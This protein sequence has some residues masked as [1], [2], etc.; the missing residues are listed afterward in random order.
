MLQYFNRLDGSD[1]IT[2][3]IAFSKNTLSGGAIEIT[4]FPFT[5]QNGGGTNLFYPQ[6]AVLFD[7][8]SSTTNNIV[9][10]G[11]NNS[12]TGILIGGN[13]GTADH[14]GLPTTTLGSTPMSLRGTLTYFAA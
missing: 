9:L 5:L 4:G 1:P 3:F 13:G 6:T 7:N 14:V 11:T 8:L 12:S 10:Q 2:F